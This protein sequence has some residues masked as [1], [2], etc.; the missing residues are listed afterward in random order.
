MRQRT[1]PI[2]AFTLVELVLVVA[3]I[4]VLSAIAMPRYSASIHNFRV[5]SGARRLAADVAMAQAQARAASASRTLAFDLAGSR[6]G[7]TG[8]RGLDGAANYTVNLREPPYQCAITGLNLANSGNTIVFDGYGVPSTGG[9]V[10]LASG[11][12]TRTVTISAASGRVTV[13]R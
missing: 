6:Y 9:T 12:M 11:S 1:R 2:P 10:V 13:T 5:G 8:I 7:I 3:V 4:G